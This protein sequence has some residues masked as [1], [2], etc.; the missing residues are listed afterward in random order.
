MLLINNL[1]KAICATKAG[2]TVI[3]VRNIPMIKV[4]AWNWTPEACLN[5]GADTETAVVDIF[6]GLDQETQRRLTCAPKAG[7]RLARAKFWKET[8]KTLPPEQ[9]HD[10]MLKILNWCV[11]IGGRTA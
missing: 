2:E 5:F 4:P 7:E 1:K 9:Y 3:A 6:R 8:L 10:A 11:R